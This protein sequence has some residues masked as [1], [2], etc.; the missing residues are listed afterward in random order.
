LVGWGVER[1]SAGCLFFRDASSSR[2]F[3]ELSASLTRQGID[4][5]FV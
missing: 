5:S 1:G 4:N 3:R 2:F